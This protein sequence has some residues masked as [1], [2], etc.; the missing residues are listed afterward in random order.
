MLLPFYSSYLLTC[1]V[2][3]FISSLYPRRTQP[4]GNTN[5]TSSC[6]CSNSADTSNIWELKSQCSSELQPLFEYFER[7]WINTIDLALWNMHEVQRRTNNN[8]EGWH[9][10][11]NR[12]GVKAHADIY[13]FISKLIQEQEVTE[14]LLAQIGAGNISAQSKNKK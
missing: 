2:S 13:E 6:I 9:L 14:T 3:R 1:T 12:R 5:T 11:L 10:R 8:L 7:H 4:T